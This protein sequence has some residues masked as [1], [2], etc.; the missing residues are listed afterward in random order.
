M[1]T[2]A[3]LVCQE[4]CFG[5]TKHVQL[6]VLG[7]SNPEYWKWV[8]SEDHPNPGWWYFSS[9]PLEDSKVAKIRS[10]KSGKP[11][12][13]L[14]LKAFRHL[15]AALG[16]SLGTQ[17]IKSGSLT[18]R[19]V[20]RI[21]PPEGTKTKAPPPVPPKKEAAEVK[22]RV[23]EHDRVATRLFEEDSESEE[24]GRGGVAAE[25]AGVRRE[26]MGAGRGRK[27]KGPFGAGGTRTSPPSPLSGKE[28]AGAR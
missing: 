8:E 12:P 4:Q 1:G 10:T 11:E 14:P 17:W 15:D 9:K 6:H 22:K 25:L 24:A 21:L 18:Y 27:D 20:K 28:D 13:S 19:A 2:F 5:K 16:P 3:A 23:K 26:V 7:A